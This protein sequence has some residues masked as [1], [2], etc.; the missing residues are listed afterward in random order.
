MLGFL[1]V[2]VF[3]PLFPLSLVFNALLA[4]VRPPG[5][6]AA[7]I[8][9]W[10]LAGVV[11]VSLLDP[12]VPGWVAAW[13]LATA[14]LYALRL[15][16]VRE[17]GTWAG[18]FA[19][20]AAA[21]AWLAVGQVSVRHLAGFVSSFALSAAAL[22]FMALPVARRLGAAYAGLPAGLS[23]A[24]RLGLAL[25]ILL[26]VAV[27]TPPA[28]AFFGLLRLLQLQ[29]LPVQVA[30]LAIWLLWAWASVR[31]IAGFLGGERG[32]AS[33]EDLGP[34]GVFGVAALLFAITMAGFI[35]PGGVS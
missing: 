16:T 10:P 6:R 29:P 33:M 20:S 13:A 3:L 25:I 27:G 12:V 31:L 32:R 21:L 17:L 26:L 2:A 24:P 4:R 8:F 15:V 35:I 1:A 23:A 9:A 22:A 30:V 11:A 18:F 34:A 5:W 14:A 7:L 19:T 28:P